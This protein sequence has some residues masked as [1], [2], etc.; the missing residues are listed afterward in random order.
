MSVTIEAMRDITAARVLQLA[1]C[2]L[3]G[4]KPSNRRFHNH[5]DVGFENENP[6]KKVLR[7]DQVLLAWRLRCPVTPK[8]KDLATVRRG[9]CNSTDSY[10]QSLVV[11]KEVLW[12]T[13]AQEDCRTLFLV[14]LFQNNTAQHELKSRGSLMG[15]FSSYMLYFL[16]PRAARL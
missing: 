8:A 3:I 1:A 14:P 9:R 12:L 15:N 6:T 4:L 10:F 7:A 16:G 2:Y 13:A 5:C 11:A